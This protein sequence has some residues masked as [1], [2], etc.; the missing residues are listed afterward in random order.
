MHHGLLLHLIPGIGRT[1]YWRLIDCFGSPEDV[2]H[3]TQD[4]LIAVNG[5]SGSLA[6]AILSAPKTIDIDAE[7]AL[8]ERYD[9]RIVSSCDSALYPATLL[10][11]NPQPPFLYMRGSLTDNDEFPITVV[12]SRSCTPYGK[13]MCERIVAGLVDYGFTIV[14]GA[15][16]GID[17]YAHR[18]AL[19]HGG[20]S[21]AVLPSGL[22]AIKSSRTRHLVEEIV[23][24]GVVYSEYPMKRHEDRSTYSARN[25]ILAGMG[26]ATVVI[27]ASLKSG[28][29]MTAYFAIEEN[30]DVFAVPGDVTRRTGRGCNLL[31]KQGAR[32][33]ESAD[34]IVEDLQQTI[35]K[36]F[37]TR[38]DTSD[39]QQKNE[40]NPLKGLTGTEQ[41]LYDIISK[42]PV[43]F[44]DLILMLGTEKIGMLS[45]SLL[46]LEMKGLVRQLPGNVY[47]IER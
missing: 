45:T 8:I 31:I 1:L 21:I 2:F 29:L 27:E 43:S 5:L 6:L 20:R 15:A 28:S 4:E 44:E 13:M 35:G 36:S 25:S 30:R 41:H 3:A 42:S 32:L 18:A 39:H 33:I 40:I 16:T 19:K 7:R 34:D 22:G 11:M 24:N 14:S 38:R 46:Q 26:I 12:G 10:R 9:A 37:S 23:S 47:T 17:T